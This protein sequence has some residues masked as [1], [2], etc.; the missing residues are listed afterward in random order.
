M[1]WLPTASKCFESILRFGRKTE[2][3]NGLAMHSRHRGLNLR[4]SPKKICWGPT[5]VPKVALFGDR[6]FTEGSKVK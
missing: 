5:P 4:N 6:V 1:A 2:L 3:Y